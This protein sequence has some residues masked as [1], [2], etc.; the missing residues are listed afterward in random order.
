VR[1]H[2][3]VTAP[4]SDNLRRSI[5]PEGQS[6]TDTRRLYS[7]VRVL[8]DGRLHLSVDGPAFGTRGGAFRAEATARL[9]DLFPQLGARGA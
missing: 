1:A 9:R 5:L 7:G 4:L 2:Q 8:P 6:L 3:L